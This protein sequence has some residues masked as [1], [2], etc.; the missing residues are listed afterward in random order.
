MFGINHRIDYLKTCYFLDTINFEDNDYIIDIGANNGDFSRCFEE[1]INY[2]GVEPS[3][4]IFECLKHNIILDNYKCYN[5]IALDGSEEEVLFYIKDEG[6]DS[7]AIETKNYT[8]KIMIKTI[9]LDKI[10][11]N[12]KCKKIKLVKI[13]AEGAEPEV[14][15]GIKGKFS[16]IEYIVIDVSAER[17]VNNNYT[18]VECVNI[19][20][21]NNF[22]LENFYI[23]NTKNERVTA[24]F[25]NSFQ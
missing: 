19:L 4:K 3:P 22:R 13:E 17:G 14:L 16:N 21:K 12:T 5:E 9:T 11:S 7:S 6:A 1:K 24:L 18:I 23:E 8:D 25:K 10:I 15:M 20:A 2:V